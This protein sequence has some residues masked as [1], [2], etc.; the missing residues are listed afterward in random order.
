[1]TACQG[2][3]HLPEPARP[4]ATAHLKIPFRLKQPTDGLDGSATA[5]QKDDLP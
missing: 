4:G 2:P 1:M 5:T 3:R